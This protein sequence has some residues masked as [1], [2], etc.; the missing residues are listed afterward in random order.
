MAIDFADGFEFYGA[1]GARAETALTRR[2]SVAENGDGRAR[3]QAGR[4]GG[5]SMQIGEGDK[6]DGIQVRVPRT[7][8]NPADGEICRYFFNYN[9][10]GDTS[11]GINWLF[12]IGDIRSASAPT[13]RLT[14]I[15]IRGDGNLYFLNEATTITDT[16]NLIHSLGSGDNTWHSI[17]M[18]ITWGATA[19]VTFLVDG[20]VVATFANQTIVSYSST[21]AT[22]HPI[23][24]QVNEESANTYR[25]L[26]DDFI[27]SRDDGGANSFRP[28]DGS[29]ISVIQPE[30]DTAQADFSS[31]GATGAETID[32]QPFSDSDYIFSDAA[33][34]QS[35]F[36]VA[37]LALESG[38]DMV[39][40]IV[41]SRANNQEALNL[42]NYQ[43]YLDDGVNTAALIGSQL[44]PPTGS[45]GY[46][47]QQ[48]YNTNPLSGAAWTQ[49]ELNGMIIGVQ[50]QA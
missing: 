13:D 32:E 10:N 26:I 15:H 37:D 30:S 31:T 50:S 6:E 17:V 20:V 11:S 39:G 16:S 5:L 23:G 44:T 49:A 35:N 29:R 9:H 47:S 24:F 21:Q 34:E 48:F 28:A 40:M 33:S 12:G 42:L 7:D 22:N 3:L 27:V 8:H 25:G 19:A 46:E 45:F 18:E 1:S 43:M 41:H 14:G 2:W 36:N 4:Y 38:L